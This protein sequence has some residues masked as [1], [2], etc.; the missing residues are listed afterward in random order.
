MTPVQICRPHPN[1]IAGSDL[2]GDVY[3]VCWD[4]RLVPEEDKEPMD[5]TP[6]MSRIVSQN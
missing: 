5:Y 3:Y 6:M 2:D 4:P 1:E